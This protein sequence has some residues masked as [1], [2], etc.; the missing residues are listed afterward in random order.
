MNDWQVNCKTNEVTVALAK[1]ARR[2]GWKRGG[3]DDPEGGFVIFWLWSNGGSI[4]QGGRSNSMREVTIPEAMDLLQKGPP[5]GLTVRIEGVD[6]PVEINDDGSIKIGC[7]TIPAKA[8]RHIKEWVDRPTL[9]LNQHRVKFFVDNS[10]GESTRINWNGHEIKIDK[11]KEILASVEEKCS[12]KTTTMDENED[13][14]KARE[15]IAHVRRAWEGTA[16][17]T[18]A[19]L[20]IATLLEKFLDKGEDKKD[21]VTEAPKTETGVVEEWQCNECTCGRPC[22]VRIE[23]SKVPV[24]SPFKKMCL[25]KVDKIPKWILQNS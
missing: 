25:C 13:H 8:I 2:F 15:D 12:T 22:N 9:M 1:M 11:I 17:D 21:D 14:Q 4:V 20:R 10:T 23:W 19:A 6:K 3:P 24:N 5:K 18:K 16:D 7:Q